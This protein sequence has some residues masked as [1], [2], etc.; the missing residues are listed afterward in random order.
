MKKLL[1]VFAFSTL[2]GCIDYTL[3]LDHRSNS[4]K[5][6]EAILK[7]IEDCASIG[8]GYVLRLWETNEAG[9]LGPST[10]NYS[11]MCK[12]RG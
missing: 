3:D 9:S 5:Q 7:E 2:T 11:L 6:F 1:I 10:L 8:K 4:E 12:T